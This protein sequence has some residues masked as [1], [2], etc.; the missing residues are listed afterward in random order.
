MATYLIKRLLQGIVVLL[1]VSF[2][3]FIMFRYTGD[4]VL[5]LAGKYATQQEREMVR[6]SYG[7]DRPMAVQ[8]VSFIG[9]VLKGNF[10]KSYISSVD[11]LDMI[12][13]RMPATLELAFTAI[14][15][16]FIL[17]VGLGVVVSVWPTGVITRAI[18][19]G[20]IFGISIPTFLIGILLVMAF[21]VYLEILPSFG[22]GETVQIGFW[23]TGLLTV[24]GWKHIILPAFTLSGYQLAVLLRLTRAGM[25]EVLSEEYIKTAW[26]K[27][28]S[29]FKVILKHALRNVLIPV[30]TIA[31]L[32]FG[33]LVAFSIVTETIFQWPGMGNLLLTSIFETDQPVIVTYI[34]LA[35]VIILTINILVDLMYAFLNPKIRYE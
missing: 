35:A 28:L 30:V 20:S 7:L 6:A 33:E 21:S 13:E 2:V 25:R 26:A 32:S 4:P 11:A 15:I 34:M 9:G 31:G 19:A 29:P 5:M 27:G 18:M 8:Y 16:S 3:C 10:G 23:R 24:D 17:G 12:L 1:A 22:R 14:C